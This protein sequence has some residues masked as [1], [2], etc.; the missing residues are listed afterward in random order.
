VDEF[1]ALG[2]KRDNGLCVMLEVH[3]H[4]QTVAVISVLERARQQL[5]AR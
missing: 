2:V 3:D 4:A 1:E 5:G